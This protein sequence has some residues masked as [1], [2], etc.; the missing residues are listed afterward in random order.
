MAKCWILKKIYVATVTEVLTHVLYEWTIFFLLAD[1]IFCVLLFYVNDIYAEW[2]EQWTFCEYGNVF[3]KAKR[4]RQLL[5]TVV[6][7]FFDSSCLI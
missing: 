5:Q 6:N 2:N 1:Y 7:F 3:S 4:E